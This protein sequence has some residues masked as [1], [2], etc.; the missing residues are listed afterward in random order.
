METS[1]EEDRQR[2]Q[3]LPMFLGAEI[4]RDRKL[5]DIERLLANHEA[6]RADE[7]VD[8]FEV[9]G[10]IPRRD[11]PVLQRGVVPLRPR[12]RSEPQWQDLHTLR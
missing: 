6:E 7:R 3:A 1:H 11:R 5:A 9:E 4:G 10:V 8:L 2:R 12:D